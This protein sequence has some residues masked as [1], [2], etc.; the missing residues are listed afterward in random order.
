MS[1]ERAG[2]RREWVFCAY[3]GLLGPVAFQ[4][5]GVRAEAIE[6][7]SSAQ[8]IPIFRQTKFALKRRQP[9]KLVE[10]RDSAGF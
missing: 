1:T 4:K 9:V 5:S 3:S 7:F 2:A 8:I 10:S 6:K